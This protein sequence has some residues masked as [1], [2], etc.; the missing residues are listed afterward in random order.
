MDGDKTGSKG[1]AHFS[2][3]R[4]GEVKPRTVGNTKPM[5]VTLTDREATFADKGSHTEEC[6]QGSLY[7]E[8]AFIFFSNLNRR[9]KAG[10]AFQ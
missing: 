2:A 10:F 9:G 1:R 8:A 5:L 4:C 7:W 3:K 6:E